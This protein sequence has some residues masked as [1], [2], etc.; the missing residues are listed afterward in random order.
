MTAIEPDATATIG[1]DAA[2]R[3]RRHRVPPAHAS[4]RRLRQRL[5]RTSGLCDESPNT[6]IT[7]TIRMSENVLRPVL[8]IGGDPYRL[9]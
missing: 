2:A 4:V 3:P 7:P 6:A 1:A 9:Q 5:T 8:E